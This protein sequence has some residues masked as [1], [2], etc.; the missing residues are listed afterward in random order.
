MTTDSTQRDESGDV[1]SACRL[2]V[3][4]MGDL[5]GI[6]SPLAE[7]AYVLA[8]TID[9]GKARGMGAAAVARELRETL[10]TL[11]EASDAGSSSDRLDDFLS[12]AVVNP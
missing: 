6:Q 10:T 7:S 8:R 3:D 5:T 12:S 2:A 9:S 1:E 11:K 4:Q